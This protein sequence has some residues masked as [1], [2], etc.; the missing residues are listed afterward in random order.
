MPLLKGPVQ[1][2]KGFGGAGGKQTPFP[3]GSREVP[4]NTAAAAAGAALQGRLKPGVTG[5]P[6]LPTARSARTPVL[7][8]RA[9]AGKVG[10]TVRGLEEREGRDFGRVD[11]ENLSELQ[12]AR[13]GPAETLQ[14]TP[15]WGGCRTGGGRRVWKGRKKSADSKGARE[16]VSIQLGLQRYGWCQRRS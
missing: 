14:T 15:S 6:A 9:A 1:T 16:R 8:T 13:Q 7:R 5:G 3:R 2:E 10:R 12:M 4:G 11:L